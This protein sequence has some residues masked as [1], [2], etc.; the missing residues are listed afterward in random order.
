[1]QSIL[2]KFRSGY[3]Q[4]RIAEE[5]V[6]KTAFRTRYGHYE[7]LVMPCGLTNAPA[8]FMHLMQQTFRKYLDDFCHRISF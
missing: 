8:T 2:A 3:H 7:F 4:V 1:V 6:P 5:D